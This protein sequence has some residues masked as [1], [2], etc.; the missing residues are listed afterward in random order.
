MKMQWMPAALLAATICLPAHAADVT[1]T[2]AWMRASVQGQATSGAYMTLTAREPLV[3]TGASTPVA[4]VAEVHQMRM[5]GDVMH[6]APVEGGL[7]LVP[8]T[9][10]ELKPGGYHIMLMSLKTQLRPQTTVPLT[11]HFRNAAGQV[12][13]VQLSVPVATSQPMAHMHQ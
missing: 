6:M 1:V 10:V 3:L 12:S 2:N 5:E 11:L 9:P 7:K 13:D 4:G 8:G